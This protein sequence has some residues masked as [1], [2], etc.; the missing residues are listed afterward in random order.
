M[1][2]KVTVAYYATDQG[3]TQQT[4]NENITYY[5]KVF[6]IPKALYST[7]GDVDF[8]KDIEELLEEVQKK[9]LEPV[10]GEATIERYETWEIEDG[11]VWVMYRVP[12]MGNGK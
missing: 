9:G 3:V 5:G 8:Q 6:K 11:N 10:T 12:C 1:G 4:G 7:A 2:Y